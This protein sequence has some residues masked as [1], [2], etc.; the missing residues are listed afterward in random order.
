MVA[1]EALAWHRPRTGHVTPHA[2]GTRESFTP[3]FLQ[4]FSNE[5]LNIFSELIDVLNDFLN[6]FS[7]RIIVCQTVRDV[8][9]FVI[10]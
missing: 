6:R 5:F 2:A 8:T 10:V 1:G 9:T 4:R 7:T 3:R